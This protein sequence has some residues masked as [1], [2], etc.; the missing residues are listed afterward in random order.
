MEKRPAVNRRCGSTG[1]DARDDVDAAVEC[2]SADGPAT[3]DLD[4]GHRQQ[5]RD[6]RGGPAVN[7][8]DRDKEDRRERGCADRNTLDRH[9]KRFCDGGGRE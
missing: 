9:R 2:D 7:V 5:S 8:G 1:R 6:G 4:E 3:C